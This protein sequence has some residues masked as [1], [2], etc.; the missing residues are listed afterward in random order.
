MIKEIINAWAFFYWNSWQC[1]I[2]VNIIKNFHK[3]KE[4]AKKAQLTW[5]KILFIYREI[6]VIS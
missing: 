6:D 3:Q 2:R 4:D 1:K 5:C